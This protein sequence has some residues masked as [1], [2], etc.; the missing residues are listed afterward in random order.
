MKQ[1]RIVLL[2]LTAVFLF[3]ACG[4]SEEAQRVDDLIASVGEISLDSEVRILEAEKAVSQL[5]EKEQ[6]SLDNLALL[7]EARAKY[8]RLL[9]DNVESFITAIGTVTLDSADAIQAAE[10]E[11]ASLD[12]ALQPEV[13]NYADLA[14]AKEAYRMAQVS[15]IQEA[16]AAIGTV[17]LESEDTIAAAR[18]VYEKYDSD[19]QSAVDNYDLL[20]AA[21]DTLL[22]LR[23]EQVASMIAAIGTVT[24][25][26]KEA[27]ENAQN[28]LRG[29][30]NEEKNRVANA[31]VLTQ[32]N[33]TY[34]ELE[35]A[36]KKQAALDEA[37]SLIQ[38]TGIWVSKPDSAG[39][40][41]LYFNF[42]NKSDKVIKYVNFGATFYNKVGDVVK[43]EY[44][45][46][47]VNRCYST[48]PFAKG[49]GLSGYGWY[50]GDYYNW[51]IA[52]VKLVSL[53]IEYMDG[54]TYTFDDDQI[55]YVQY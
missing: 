28:A 46:A 4:K 45:N 18:A 16:I 25:D 10:R 26:S 43:C 23:A 19:I 2:V 12:E 54:S 52:S 30:T 11:Y 29:L 33:T 38:V 51:D 6:K 50:W 14:A 55:A 20:T 7:Q 31:D 9:V 5:E 13:E 3:V 48:G 39:G 22:N 34:K 40:V 35:K 41:E 36:A 1:I 47:R 44:E 15:D 37:R 42:V 17:T 21:E 49:E 32:A 8:N 27:I 53:D 24:L